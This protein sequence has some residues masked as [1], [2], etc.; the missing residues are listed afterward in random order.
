MK[1]LSLGEWVEQAHDVE[2]AYV[3]LR[4]KGALPP[5]VIENLR[6]L[7]RLDLL[8]DE[9]VLSLIG[10]APIDPVGVFGALKGIGAWAFQG[11]DFTVVRVLAKDGSLP[12]ALMRIDLLSDDIVFVALKNKQLVEH[13]R[14]S[15]EEM[16]AKFREPGATEKGIMAWIEEK[17]NAAVEAGLRA[18][19][20]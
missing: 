8:T 5:R 2:D 7:H 6:H 13:S 15:S 1:T 17:A 9:A 3:R 4:V 20:Q 16:V 19:N 18:K 11:M 10:Q 12:I 14:I